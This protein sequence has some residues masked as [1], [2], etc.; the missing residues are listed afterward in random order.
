MEVV[1]RPVN[2]RLILLCQPDICGEL[3]RLCLCG[4]KCLKR[5]GR[6]QSQVNGICP[7]KRPVE[8]RLVRFEPQ[9][10]H[11]I[12]QLPRR[13]VNLVLERVAVRK[14]R[15]RRRKPVEKRRLSRFGITGQINRSCL[16]D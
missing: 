5:L 9:R 7:V 1:R 6:I 4:V 8:Q 16:G 13:C 10:E 3:F 15:L 11:R 12:E 14:N 2:G